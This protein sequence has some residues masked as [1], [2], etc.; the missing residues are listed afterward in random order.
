LEEL[1]EKAFIAKLKAGDEQ[2]FQTLFEQTAPKLCS[3]ISKHGVIT[4][5]DAEE[6]AVDR[7]DIDTDEVQA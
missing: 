6:L 4:P 2:S 7:V 3:F 1:N 5:E